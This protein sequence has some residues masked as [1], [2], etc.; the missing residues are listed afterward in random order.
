VLVEKPMPVS[1]FLPQNLN[2][3]ARDQ[4]R[5]AV[6]EDRQL[7]ESNEVH[8]ITGHEDS[9]VEWRYSPNFFN[10]GIRCG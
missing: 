6:V 9:E 3:L 10:F 4:T 8:P 1:H 2:G 5:P 7:K